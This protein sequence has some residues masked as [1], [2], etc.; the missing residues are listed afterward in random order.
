[1][2]K[3][4][5]RMAGGQEVYGCTIGTGRLQATVLTYGATLNR[6]VWRTAKGPLDVVLG[7][8][9]LEAILT[10]RQL[11][12]GSVVGPF[13]NRI[14][15]ARMVID[16]APY[17]LTANDGASCLHGGDAGTDIAVWQL[18]DVAPDRVALQLTCPDGAGGFPGPLHLRAAY[19]LDDEELRLDLSATTDAPTVISLASHAYLNLAGRGTIDGHVLRV[20]ARQLLAVDEHGIPTGVESV[21]DVALDLRAGV[22]LGDLRRRDHRLVGM[23][24][25]L[26]LPFLPDGAGTRVLAELTLPSAGRSMHLRS[27]QDC[28]QVYTGNSL[29]S[30][31]PGHAGMQYREADGLA[32]EPQRWPDSPNQTWMP[33]P[34]LRPRETYA[35]TTSWSFREER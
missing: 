18:A 19:V 35:T 3:S 28:L 12:L 29:R 10:H 27:D 15:G 17:A 30:S 2:V 25:G 32:L 33:S 6:L 20:P 7:L 26:D 14:S 1:M 5:G 22:E 4:W 13:A 21:G 23:L 9:S 16:G 11:F 8:T 24:G 31:A 34:S